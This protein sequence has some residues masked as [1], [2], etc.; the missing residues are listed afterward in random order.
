MRVHDDPTGNADTWRSTRVGQHAGGQ[1][2]Q[3]YDADGGD[4][5]S[6]EGLRP[7]GVTEPK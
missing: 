6:S 1:F 5:E 3:W 7:F 4:I 2:D